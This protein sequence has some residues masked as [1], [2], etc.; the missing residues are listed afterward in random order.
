MGDSSAEPVYTAILHH[1]FVGT[2]RVPHPIYP[3]SFFF[4]LTNL[5]VCFVQIPYPWGLLHIK[6]HIFAHMVS[7]TKCVFIALH[8]CITMEKKKKKKNLLLLRIVLIHGKEGDPA[9]HSTTVVL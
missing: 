6:L 5:T 8:A 4:K 9:I 1:A 2:S 7:L 3:F